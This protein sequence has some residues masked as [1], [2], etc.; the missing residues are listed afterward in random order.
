MQRNMHRSKSFLD[1]F[2]IEAGSQYQKQGLFPRAPTSH[3]VLIA[4]RG[5]AVSFA[6]LDSQLTQQRKQTHLSLMGEETCIKAA[7]TWF[8]RGS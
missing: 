7:L 5:I 4:K 1:S 6:C 8:Q 3:S 2:N